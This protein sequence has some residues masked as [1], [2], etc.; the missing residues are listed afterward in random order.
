[1]KHGVEIFIV[2]GCF[3]AAGPGQFTIIESTMNSSLYPRVLEE[4]VRP[5]FG[6]L[7][8]KRM[9]TM[10]HDNDPKH[11]SKSTKEW[12]KRKK[13][14][15]LEWPSQ[16]PDLN[17]IEMLWGDLKRAVH[18]RN[19]SITQLKR[20]CMEEWEKLSPSW[21]KKLV[22]SYRKRLIEV[23]SVKGGNTSYWGIGC[24]NFSSGGI[25]IFVN[26]LLNKWIHG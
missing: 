15:V 14:R 1:M 26:I 20:F 18:A 6:K 22:D 21:C 23:I 11:S 10:Q 24:P 19:P 9:W 4:N 7:K 2:W 25:G 13:W 5:S 12:L 16:T 8:L 3:A 17:S